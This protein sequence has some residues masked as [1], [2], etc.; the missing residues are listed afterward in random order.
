MPEEA[1][2]LMITALREMVEGQRATATVLREMREDITAL[3]DRLA[4][5]E[6]RLAA[7][8]QSRRGSRQPR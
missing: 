2:D 6:K 7:K 4:L 5:V 1:I 3:S 8:S